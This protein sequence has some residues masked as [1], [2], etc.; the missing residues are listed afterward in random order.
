SWTFRNFTSLAADAGSDWTLTGKNTIAS[1]LDNGALTIAPAASLTVTSNVDPNS[2][3]VFKLGG[4][5][6]LEVAAAIGMNTKM[7]FL[8]GDGRLVIDHFE[9]FGTNVGSASYAG[10]QLQDFT[11]GDVIDLLPFSAGGAVLTYDALTGVLQISNGVSQLAS[12]SF[13]NSTLGGGSFHAT[14]DGGA[15]LLI[16]R[17]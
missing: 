8:G 9:A 16:M 7:S 1:I 5:S 12:L 10:P 2:A 13:Q 11:S 6:T 4:G 3:G 17:G 14:S 15:G